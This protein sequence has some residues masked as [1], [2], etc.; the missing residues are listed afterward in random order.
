MIRRVARHIVS[1]KGAS[2]REYE[3]YV[4]CLST[5]RVGTQT[6]ASLGSL[7]PSVAA[8]HEPKPLAFGLSRA[9]F[10][11][12]RGVILKA[13]VAAI[14]DVQPPKLEKVYLETSPQLT[15]L[16]H[17]LLEVFPPSQ[18]IHVVRHPLAVVQSGVRRGWYLNHPND[19]WRLQPAS[20]V[21][22]ARWMHYSQAE[23]IMALWTVTNTWID[24]FCSGL[25]DSRWCRLKSEEIFA[26][27]NR[28]LSTFFQQLRTEPP[29]CIRLNRVLRKKL[30]RQRSGGPMTLTGAETASLREI[31]GPLALAY[32]YRLD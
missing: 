12:G 16:A 14:R 32:G 1:G 26:G 18:F 11:D 9:A 30:N 31:C 20:G 6:L 25:P 19:R 2:H 4:F 28:A 24:N 27:E 15:F 17:C 29:S 22:A 8:F 13:A 5:G 21:H 7:A 10:E 3:S 23:K